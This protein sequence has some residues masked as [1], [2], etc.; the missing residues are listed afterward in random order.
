MQNSREGAKGND[1][2]KFWEGLPMATVH[3]RA[4]WD[5]G[6][7]RLFSSYRTEYRKERKVQENYKRTELEG[8]LEIF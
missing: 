7:V 2:G 8:T 3:K 1:R 6:Q 5:L 4:H